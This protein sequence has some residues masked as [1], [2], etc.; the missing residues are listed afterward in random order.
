[1]EE[2]AR[3]AS[4]KLGQ[5]VTVEMVKAVQSAADKVR[6]KLGE[7]LKRPGADEFVEIKSGPKMEGVVEI[8]SG[9]RRW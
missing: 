6:Y 7:P 9:E 3:L 1:L 2:I 5:V 4:E 8:K